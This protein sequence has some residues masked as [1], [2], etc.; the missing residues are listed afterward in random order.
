MVTQDPMRGQGRT[1]GSTSGNQGVTEKVQQQAGQV[2]EQAGQK[3]GE[4]KE[5]VAEQATSRAEQGKEQATSSLGQMAGAIRQTSG[6]LRSQDQTG[7]AQYVD[8]AADQVE[9]LSSYLNNR[10][11]TELVGDVER[12]ARREPTLFLG[13]A[14]LLGLVGARFLKS[15]GQSSQVSSGGQGYSSQGYSSAAYRGTTQPPSYSSYALPSQA[16]SP[17]MDLGQ[18]TGGAGRTSGS[19][20]GASTGT[21][22][23]STSYSGGATTGTSASSTPGM[24]SGSTSYSTGTTSGTSASG[25]GQSTGLPVGMPTSGGAGAV[26]DVIVG[27]PPITDAIVGGPPIDRPSSEG[28]R[29]TGDQGKERS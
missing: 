1:G 23:G 9:N 18:A 16:T 26:D 27:G 29:G 25:I 14:F 21:I 6:Q 12:F 8:R 5:Q 22:S 4:V 17:A 7:I 2:M 13:G 11:V 20:Y 28:L 10:S 3:V 15:S 19:G 24:S